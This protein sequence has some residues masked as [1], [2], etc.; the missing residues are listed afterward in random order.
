PR[1][2]GRPVSEVHQRSRARRRSRLR[3]TPLRRP[4]PRASTDPSRDYRKASTAPAQFGSA[5]HHS[6]ALRQERSAARRCAPPARLVRSFVPAAAADPRSDDR[7]TPSAA[8]S[9]A[10]DRELRSVPHIDL[11][12]AACRAWMRGEGRLRRLRAMRLASLALLAAVT[13]AACAS[14]PSPTADAVAL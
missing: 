4:Q 13:L 6:L 7:T 8:R 14:D 3:A 2:V 12:S 9:A 1:S 11:A 5:W 10:A